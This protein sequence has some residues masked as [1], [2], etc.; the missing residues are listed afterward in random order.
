MNR[1]TSARTNAVRTPEVAVGALIIAAC[2]VGAMTW[3]R[4]VVVGTSVLVVTSDVKRGEVL[5]ESDF[6]TITLTS[7]DDIDLVRA[8][9][10]EDA[11][12]LRAMTDISAGT[13]LT[14]SQLG[15]VSPIANDEGLVGLTVALGEAPADIDAGDSVRL[16][17][18]T[19]RTDGST[20][21]AIEPAV[22]EVW[23][24]TP[25]DPMDGSRVVTLKV[26]VEEAITFL[27]REEIRLMKVN[28]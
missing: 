12:G 18:L 2:V 7:S 16:L 24:I 11:V 25:S 3:S 9:S 8:A 27:G 23:H 21:S 22:F 5:Q 6:G 28:P 19:R 26:G 13:P 17:T 20:A 4:S 15:S 1:L 10:L 14:P